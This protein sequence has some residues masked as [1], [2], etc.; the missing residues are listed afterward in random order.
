MAT[1]YE[2]GPFRLEADA[3]MLFRGAEPVALG[4]RA[5]ALLRLLL[6]KAGKPVTKDA[7]M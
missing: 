6:E 3:D 5:V 4:G 2:F 7:L 1:I